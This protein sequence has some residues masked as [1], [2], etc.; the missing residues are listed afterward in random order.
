M[1]PKRF[2]DLSKGLAAAT[3]R[4]SLVKGI[5]GGILGGA[6]ALAGL[7]RAGAKPARV[8]VCH[9]TGNVNI[10]VAYVEVSTST[11]QVLLSRGDTLLG[12]VTDCGTCGNACV[13]ND[14]CFTAACDGSS[15]GYSP[16][17]PTDCTVSDWSEWSA[18]SAECGGGA[19]TR[20]RTVITEASCGGTCPELSESVSCNEQ[21]CGQICGETT[22]VPGGACLDGECFTQYPNCTSSYGVVSNG[23]GVNACICGSG[24]GEVCETSGACPDGQVCILIPSGDGYTGYCYT[25]CP[26]YD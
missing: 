20:T 25:G 21:P 3:S 11:A 2:D 4:R 9:K 14:A 16:V 15:C 24:S 17:A 8:G 5:G 22:C 12:A 19:T 10:P 23:G 6:L 7:G 18:C 1:D 13:S 26:A